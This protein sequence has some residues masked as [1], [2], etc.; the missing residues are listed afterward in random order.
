KAVDARPLGRVGM[1][2][3]MDLVR[4]AVT[5][6]RWRNGARLMRKSLSVALV[7]ALAWVA[8]A[9]SGTGLAADVPFKVLSAGKVA[10]QV[11]AG[12]TEVRDAKALAQIW[13][14]LGL[15]GPCPTVKF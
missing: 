1:A 13:S 7:L 4:R 11:E 5:L 14:R 8:F 15:K 9:E 3:K 10:G 6:Q 2:S 12:L